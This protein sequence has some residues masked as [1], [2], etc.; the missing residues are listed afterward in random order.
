MRYSSDCEGTN[1]RLNMV[2]SENVLFRPMSG[3][4]LMNKNFRT[5]SNTAPTQFRNSSEQAPTTIPKRLAVPADQ[6]LSIYLSIYQNTTTYHTL[7]YNTINRCLFRWFQGCIR[8]I[9][10]TSDN[11][12]FQ[13]IIARNNHKPEES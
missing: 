8:H 5:S 2:A 11:L 12:I 4:A 7:L 13:L 9:F 1:D 10:L 6:N 3:C